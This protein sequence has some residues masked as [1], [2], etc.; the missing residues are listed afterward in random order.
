MGLGYA[1]SSPARVVQLDPVTL[2]PR[3][4]PT[5]IPVP[6]LRHN[7]VLAFTCAD[8]CRLDVVATQK[9]GPGGVYAW[10]PGE[11]SPTLLDAPM[12]GRAPNTGNYLGLLD[13]HN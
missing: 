11:R 6:S 13:N 2:K 1:S 5:T 10:A 8:S 7:S 4:A 9:R 3:G 12:Q